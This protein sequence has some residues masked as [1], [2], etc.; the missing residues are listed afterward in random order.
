MIELTKAVLTP[1]GIKKKLHEFIAANRVLENS[2]KLKNAINFEGHSGISKTSSV[3]QFCVENKIGYEKVNMAN[4]D[5]LGEITGFPIKEYEFRHTKISETRWGNEKEYDLLIKADYIP[6]GEIRTGY[7][8]PKWVSKLKKHDT[9]VLILDDV[10]RSHQRFV[11]ALME[12][13]S[14]G[15]YYGWKLPKGCNIVMTNNPDDGEYQTSTLDSAQRSRFFTFWVEYNKNDWAE[16]AEK[17][18]IPGQFINFILNNSDL[19]FS[20]INDD[21]SKG[22]L[23]NPRQWSM[24]FNSL[25][26]LEG[27]FSSEQALLQ[28]HENGRAMLPDEFVSM[29]VSFLQSSEWGIP[30]PEFLFESA[31]EAVI[32][33]ALISSIGSYKSQKYRAAQSA[34][35]AM[36]IINWLKIKF[37]RHQN[38]E[39]YLSRL[40]FLMKCE[41]FGKDLNFKII[42]DLGAQNTELYSILLKNQ[43]F[44]T[45][46]LS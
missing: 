30:E 22:H 7:A 6:T 43:F 36:R 3:I 28:I 32:K 14:M 23:S 44:V 12:L 9:S 42:R 19:L 11:N 33:E 24:L 5:D 21:Q 41:V 17:E 26:N 38:F 1:R 16:N 31:N 29:F 37:T 25:A 13:I 4:I 46:V 2:G 18:Q 45:E 39:K 15:E 8:E 20:K 40:E 34:I 10:F 27:D 35:L